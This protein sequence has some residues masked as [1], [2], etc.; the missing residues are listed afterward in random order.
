MINVKKY[1]TDY[2]LTV[3]NVKN[4]DQFALLVDVLN[5]EDL[6]PYAFDDGMYDEKHN[7]AVFPPFERT[8]WE[9][10]VTDMIKIAE[11]LPDMYFQL[12]GIGESFG[13]VWCLY[14]H[15]MDI[16]SCT[17]EIVFEAPK[18]VQWTELV[19]F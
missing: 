2:K 4:K 9:G 10:H 5:K 6:I 16:E 18:K 14:F 8:V 3:R 13:D 17:G 11:Q 15:D 1:Y 19:E 7:E 12:D